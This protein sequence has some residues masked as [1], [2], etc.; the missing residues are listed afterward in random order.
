MAQAS[1]EMNSS[2]LFDIIGLKT[3]L[4][5]ISGGLAQSSGLIKNLTDVECD[6]VSGKDLIEKPIQ[7]FPNNSEIKLLD[8]LF[9]DG[10]CINGPGIISKDSLDKRRQKIINHWIKK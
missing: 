8:A 5:P 10:G 4:Y 2:C 7:K 6:V 3:R 1:S 9:C